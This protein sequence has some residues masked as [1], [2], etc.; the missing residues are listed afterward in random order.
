MPDRR[1]P[2]ATRIVSHVPF[3]EPVE[4]RLDNR[5]PVYFLPGGTEDIIKLELVSLPDHACRKNL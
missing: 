5:M 2:P 3:I 4:K 1:T